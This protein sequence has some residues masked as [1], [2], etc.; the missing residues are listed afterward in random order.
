MMK[1]SGAPEIVLA[2]VLKKR[3]FTKGEKLIYSNNK[4]IQRLVFYIYI[5]KTISTIS[6]IYG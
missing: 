1:D 4:N 3:G 6:T 5:Y 2:L